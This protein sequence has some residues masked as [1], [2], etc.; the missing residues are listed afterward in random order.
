M[1]KAE[2][3]YLEAIATVCIRRLFYLRRMPEARYAIR[4]W[5]ATLRR[6]RAYQPPCS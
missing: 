1:N 5:I 4:E 2:A 3:D 6:A